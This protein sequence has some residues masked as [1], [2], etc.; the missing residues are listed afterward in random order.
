MF[1]SIPVGSRELKLCSLQPR[2]RGDGATLHC[3]GP[4]LSVVR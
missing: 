4:R 3:M 2:Q 1:W